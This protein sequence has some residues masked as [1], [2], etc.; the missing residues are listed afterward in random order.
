MSSTR[1]PTPVGPPTGLA[2]EQHPRPY[3]SGPPASGARDI[4]APVF[5]PKILNY[6]SVSWKKLASYTELHLTAAGL[7]L[8][9]L[10]RRVGSAVTVTGCVHLTPHA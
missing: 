10:G 1:S 3:L 6:Y 7:S 5:T 8:A 2:R 4:L 9:S